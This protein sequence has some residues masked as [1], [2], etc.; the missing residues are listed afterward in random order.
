MTFFRPILTLQTAERILN[1]IQL[2]ARTNSFITSYS[3]DWKKSKRTTLIFFAAQ[4][5]LGCVF[6]VCENLCR[7]DL[8]YVIYIIT[9]F[10]FS[11]T[12]FVNMVMSN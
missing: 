7:E 11:F 8:D 10:F 2:K 9:L 12:D 1:S 3:I 6:I 4:V 5:F